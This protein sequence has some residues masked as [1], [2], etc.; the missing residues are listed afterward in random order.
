MVRG[1]SSHTASVEE[2]KSKSGH[3]LE[4]ITLDSSDEELV[5]VKSEPQEEVAKKNPIEV[6][7]DS[8]DSH[9][10]VF[11]RKRKIKSINPVNT[12]KIKQIFGSDSENEGSNA[13]GKDNEILSY[14]PT[15]GPSTATSNIFSPISSEE[16][17]Y[18][19]PLKSPSK[20]SP[21][22]VD[23]SKDELPES[24]PSPSKPISE[25]IYTVSSPNPRIPP[26]R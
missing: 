19:L 2:S 7:T 21:I 20:M 18:Q 24:C 13:T 15:P 26:Y 17:C 16:E 11:T 4:E 14:R 6:N 22:P 5:G 25:T 8:A 3:K 1:A 12:K 9:Q 23:L 10:E